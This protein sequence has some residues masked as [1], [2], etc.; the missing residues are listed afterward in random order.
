M[1]VTRSAG[2]YANSWSMPVVL[3]LPRRFGPAKRTSLLLSSVHSSTA[4]Q[5]TA[6]RLVLECRR[7]FP[8]P[9]SH[10]VIRESNPAAELTVKRNIESS[11]SEIILR[12]QFTTG[13][14]T[15]RY[16]ERMCLIGLTAVSHW[17]GWVMRCARAIVGSW[18]AKGKSGVSGK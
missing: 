6:S 5:L 10:S 3:T 9:W 17:I 2:L 11:R 13:C 16:H 8:A 4:R 15:D 14:R 1:D 18:K 7:Q 12:S